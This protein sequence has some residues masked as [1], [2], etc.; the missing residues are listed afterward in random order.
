MGKL[1][2]FEGIDG[3]GKST[4]FRLFTN[5]LEKT[6]AKFR[7]LTFPRY[8]EPSSALLKMYLNGDFGSKPEDV[9]AYASSTFY[10]VD[11]I[12]S[13]LSDWGEYY[14]G[15]GML[16]TDRYTT[17]NAIHQ[18]AKLPLQRREDYYKWLFDF[19]YNLLGLPR[20]DI[21]IYFDMPAGKSIE[22]LK[23]RQQE[24]GEKAD[25]HETEKEFLELSRTSALEAARFDG[26]YVVNCAPDNIL[27]SEEDIH[28]EVLKIIKKEVVL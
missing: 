15:G 28:D 5:W 4:Q 24:T 9:N 7:R 11:R 22:L 10:A 12:A 1:I 20:P 21:V 2:V 16:I 17:S 13:Y 27:R 3:S 8:S 6:G 23:K 18:G 26:W 14:R 19:E 25:I